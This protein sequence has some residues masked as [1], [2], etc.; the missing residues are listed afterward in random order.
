MR[1][2]KAVIM[3][4]RYQQSLS[5]LCEIVDPLFLNCIWE[6]SREVVMPSREVRVKSYERSFMRD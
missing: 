2:I 3:E 1:Y 5:D 4:F 6:T